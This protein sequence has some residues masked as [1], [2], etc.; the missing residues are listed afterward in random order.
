MSLKY[1]IGR[2]GSG[3]TTYCLNKI[4]EKL[5]E[6]PEGNNLILL[7]PEQ[8]TFQNEMELINTPNIKGMMRAQVLSFRR[9]AW[10]VLQETGGGAKVHLGDLGKRMVIRKFLEENKSQLQVFQGAADLPGFVD[11]LAEA[12]SEMK[13]YRVGVNDLKRVLEEKATDTSLLL[14]KIEDL[15]IIY[16][17]LQEYLQ[18]TYLDPDDYL[19]IL[20]EKIP[21]STIISGAEIWIDGFTGFTPQELNVIATLL[22]HA[23]RVNVTITLDKPDFSPITLSPFTETYNTYQKIKELALKNG[24]LEEEPYFLDRSIPYRFQG[25]SSLAYLEKSFFDL[26]AESYSGEIEDIKIISAQ[27]HRAEVE[28]VAREIRYLCRDKGFR[29]RDIGVLLRDFNNYDLLIE[30]IFADYEIPFFLDRKRT[31][32]HHPLVELIRSALEVVREGWTYQSVFR[33]LKTDLANISRDKVDILENFCL[34]RGIKG[35]IWYKED[36]WNFTNCDIEDINE[37]RWQAIRELKIF[38]DKINQAKNVVEVT[39]ALYELLLDLRVPQKLETWAQIAESSGRLEVS[40]EHSQIWNGIV[41]LLDQLVET[42]GEENFL[43][44]SFSKILDS[45]LE[46]IRLG[47]IPPGLDQVVVGSLDRSRNP[48]LRA[49]FVLGVSDGI[50]PARP[51]EEGIFN[52]TERELLKNMGLVLSPGSREKLLR[53]EFLVYTSLT[54]ANAYLVLSYPLA[55]LEGKALRPSLVIT[56]IKELFPKIQ[57]EH[58]GIE[59]RGPEED[60]EFISHPRRTLAYLGAKLRQAKEGLEVSPLWWEVYSWFL[61]E[62]E[63]KKDLVRVIQGLFHQNQVR[64]LNPSL[65]RKLFSNP[66]RVSVSRLEK[67]QA[68]P[69]SHFVAYG[70]KL[71]E[72]ELY[73]FQEMDLGL[74]FHEAMERFTKRLIEEK[75]DWANLSQQEILAITDTIV[76]EVAPQ[77]QNQVLLSSARY[78]YL[79]GKFKK[80]LQR[81][82]KVLKEHARRGK[83]KPIGLEIL[84]GPGGTLPGLKFILQDGTQIE[85]VGRIDRIDAAEK[86]KQYFLR[87]IDY[88]SG[89]TGLNL[90]EVFYGFKLQL[91]T[92]L[93]IVLTY[94][95]ELI[96]SGEVLPAGVLYFYLRDPLV[97]SGGPLNQ[98]KIELEILK[99]LK[100]Q[101]LVLADL[102]VFQLMD[103]ET[104]EKWSPIIPVG[105]KKE[106]SQLLKEG[107]E[108]TPDSNPL[109]LFQKKS[110]VVTK[111]QMDTI[112]RHVR[113]LIKDCGEKILAGEA[114]IAP[115]QL[116][117]F[118]ACEHCSFQVVCQFDPQV[119]GNS[120]RVLKIIDEEEIWENLNLWGK[121]SSQN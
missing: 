40:R 46:N 33:Y 10:Q 77:L 106:G 104:Q 47:L 119:E 89:S 29:Y 67:F 100:M 85:L 88:K 90:L 3:K 69:F 42:M 99:D 30:T 53:E 56:R 20:A 101:G 34:A 41:E 18:D 60:W 37:I 44:D 91:I 118:K 38:Q 54:R 51:H 71:K 16:E 22:K 55:D 116:E 107:K 1:I 43:I 92:Y 111:D 31:V 109:E 14:A 87:V 76:E 96:G 24:V 28:A 83:F 105:L 39:Q 35:S 63:R 84:F 12:I 45:G 95:Q 23:K 102:N 78:R 82:V 81:G 74:F 11:S 5:A 120:Y 64:P 27:N 108:V 9:L 113:F 25:S 17:N 7:V 65:A 72:R 26:S 62:E 36:S 49:A 93:D 52:D 86:D 115:Y 58:I 110:Q 61:E 8:A 114:A 79:T 59:P 57:E 121:I 6:S 21:Y 70:L 13:L 98:E 117:N 97:S 50:L 19:N 15:V 68:C 48:N 80:T 2:A 32:L 112:R 94:G 4:R 103:G 66:F 75:R 73:R